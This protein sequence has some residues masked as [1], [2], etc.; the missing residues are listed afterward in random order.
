MGH[1]TFVAGVAKEDFPLRT[2]HPPMDH[3]ALEPSTPASAGT[4]STGLDDEPSGL[5]RR[6]R[7]WRSAALRSPPG[8]PYESATCLRGALPL[9]LAVPCATSTAPWP[10]CG[11]TLRASSRAWFA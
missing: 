10:A 11:T 5:W 4:P 8:R 9:Y 2:P 1:P 6:Q 3:R 7:S